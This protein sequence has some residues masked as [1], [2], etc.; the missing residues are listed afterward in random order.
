MNAMRRGRK[1]LSNIWGT[2]EVQIRHALVWLA[3]NGVESGISWF[4]LHT[5]SNAKLEC[6][7]AMK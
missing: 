6:T 1:V 4:V 7:Q 5:V 3:W 2:N